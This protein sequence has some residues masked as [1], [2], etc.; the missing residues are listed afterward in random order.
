MNK[1]EKIRNTY[2]KDIGTFFLL[3]ITGNNKI[4]LLKILYVKLDEKISFQFKKN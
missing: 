2:Y 1:W 4:S 3:Q